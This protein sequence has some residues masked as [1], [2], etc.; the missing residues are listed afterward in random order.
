MH[1]AGVEMLGVGQEDHG[2]IRP[3]DHR[4]DRQEAADGAAVRQDRFA[5]DV[6]DTQA[7]AV[8]GGDSVWRATSARP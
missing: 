8:V 1:R 2:G 6:L 3:R 5:L 7:A 4:V